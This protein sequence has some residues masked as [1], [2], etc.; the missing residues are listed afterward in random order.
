MQR[1]SVL[2]IA[3]AAA[4]CATDG[5]ADRDRDRDRDAVDAGELLPFMAECSVGEHERC[6]TGLCFDFNAK[7]P[8]CTHACEVDADC[9][10]PSEGCNGMG[11]CKAPGGGGGD[12]G[13]G[14]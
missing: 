1:L 5:P 6:D 9:E 7:G 3:L 10:P 11:V 2:V 13:G 8:H 14:G 4:A 12:G